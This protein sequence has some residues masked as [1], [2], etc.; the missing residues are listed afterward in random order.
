MNFVNFNHNSNNCFPYQTNLKMNKGNNFNSFN[1]SCFNSNSDFN[2]MN[3]SYNPNYFNN[4]MMINNNFNS[5]NQIMMNSMNNNMNNNMMMNNMNNNMMMN[6]MSNNMMMNKMNNSLMMNN[7]MI[8]NNMMMNNNMKNHY[9]NSN[10]L[11]WYFTNIPKYNF[12]NFYLNQNLLEMQIQNQCLRRSYMIN[13][14]QQMFTNRLKKIMKILGKQRKIDDCINEENK[15]DNKIKQDILDVIN[16]P[17]P[18]QDDTNNDNNQNIQNALCIVNSEVFISLLNLNNDLFNGLGN[19][20]G[21]W[22]K[23]ENRGGRQYRPPPEGWIGYGLNV[24]NKYDNGNNDWLACNG[25]QGEW[26]VAYHGVARGQSSDQVKNVVKLILENN[27]KPG[28]GQSLQ[29]TP[30]DFHPG[31]LIGVGVYCSPNPL[32]LNSYAG[33]ME[34]EGVKYRVGFML[35]VKPDKIRC[36]NGSPDEWILNGNF[37]E[38]RP[39]RLL[40]KRA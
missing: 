2:R 9:Y 20:E 32:F 40:V 10:F 28:A 37:S 3:N 1:L 21:K 7:N 19:N 30:D 27:L 15:V 25:R 5:L 35:R 24:L 12:F 34:I 31:Q 8:M 39:Y 16:E 33:T 29:N 36:S 4:N 14:Y 22:A 6:N 23:N 38:I 26:C 11:N 13:Y 18:Y 17:N